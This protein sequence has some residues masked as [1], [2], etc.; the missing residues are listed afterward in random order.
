MIKSTPLFNRGFMLSTPERR[1][2]IASYVST[3]T[4]HFVGETSLLLTQKD[5]RQNEPQW[6]QHLE[7]R[8]METNN[9]KLNIE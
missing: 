4:I 2:T 8:K 1:I 6:G 9:H 7:C 3:G 5:K